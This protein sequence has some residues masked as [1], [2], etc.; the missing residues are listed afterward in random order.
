MTERVIESFTQTIH[1]GTTRQLCVLPGDAA[2]V[3]A[4]FIGGTKIDKDIGNAV[5]KM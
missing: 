4:I 5:S 3:G 1:S 2:F